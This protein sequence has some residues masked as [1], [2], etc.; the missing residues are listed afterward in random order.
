MYS[1]NKV[2]ESP[3]ECPSSQ[4]AHA[5]DKAFILSLSSQKPMPS[6][7]LFN[8]NAST[9]NPEKTTV[10]YLSI[11]Q[12]PAS[13]LDTLNTV[14]KRA[15]D[16]AKSMDSKGGRGTL[17][18]PIGAE[19]VGRT[20]QKHANTLPWKTSHCHGLSGCNSESGLSELWIGCDLLG[21][22]AAQHIVAGKGYARAIRIHKLTL[23]AI[24]HLLL[25]RTWMG[26]M[27]H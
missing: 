23:Q 1:C 10:G 11:I 4:N 6:W 17:S 18:E 20:V 27:L 22:N 2:T 7:A 14:I 16:V 15:F 8:Q 13:E 24:W 9:I 25:P 3:K 21:S 12:S 5:T 19:I 26:L